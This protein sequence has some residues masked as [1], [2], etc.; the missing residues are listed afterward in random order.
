MTSRPEFPVATVVFLITFFK[1]GRGLRIA[2]VGIRRVSAGDVIP[3]LNP[4]LN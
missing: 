1:A 3:G 2:G 4:G